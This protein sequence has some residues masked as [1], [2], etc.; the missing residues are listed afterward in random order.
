MIYQGMQQSTD[1]QD[2]VI[3]CWRVNGQVE[4]AI[5]GVSLGVVTETYGE[6]LIYPFLHTKRMQVRI[7]SLVLQE[8]S[9]EPLDGDHLQRQQ[10]QYMAEASANL[11]RWMAEKN[12]INHP[13]YLTFL[14]TKPN[15]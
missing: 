13:S 5:N 6:R 3:E 4:F 14:Q 9:D 12:D 8:L 11:I 15:N 1:W 10:R 2:I 7:S